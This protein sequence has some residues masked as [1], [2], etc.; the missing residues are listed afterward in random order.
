MKKET[1][2]TPLN[3]HVFNTTQEENQEEGN[4]IDQDEAYDLEADVY[5]K[6]SR[7]L[8][9]VEVMDELPYITRANSC[10]I[11]PTSPATLSNSSSYKI[12]KSV[13]HTV[14]VEVDPDACEEFWRLISLAYPVVMLTEG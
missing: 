11:I 4:L 1:E 5:D 9:A 6:R 2:L 13:Q 8:S 14:D 10:V 12:E 7:E 3:I